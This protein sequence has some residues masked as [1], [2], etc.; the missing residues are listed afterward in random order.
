VGAEDFDELGADQPDWRVWLG[1]GLTALWVL[2]QLYYIFD[3]V[4]FGR[5]VY[6]GPSTVGD[7][8]EGAFAPLA[9]LWLVIGFF[10]QRRELE[11]SNRAI[12]L[13]YREMRRQGEQAEIQSQAIAASE[14]HTRQDTF[15]KVAHLVTEQLGAILGLL[16][17]SSQ[18]GASGRYTDEEIGEMWGRLGSG[19]PQIFGRQLLSLHFQADTPRESYDLFFGTAIRGRH[20]ETFARHFERLIETARKCDTDGML[21]DAVLGSA[22]GRIHQIVRDH[23]DHPPAD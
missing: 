11:N 4:G 19:D 9:F 15:L 16:F 20:S 14:L 18:G 17:M 13:Q 1:L 6:E 23:A 7:F 2:L 22:H 5:F 8:L 12:R 21:T 3:I 10:L